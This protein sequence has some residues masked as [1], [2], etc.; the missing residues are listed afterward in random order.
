MASGEQT[1]KKPPLLMDLIPLS[2]PELTIRKKE[3]GGYGGQVASQS[4]L[5]H[6]SVSDFHFRPVQ[7]IP[8]P[9]GTMTD[10]GALS[11]YI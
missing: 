2:T 10:R 6:S 11:R 5:F 8:N 3:F 9:R 7:S 4:K 1:A